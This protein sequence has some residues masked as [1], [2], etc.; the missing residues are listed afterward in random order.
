MRS[1]VILEFDLPQV[2]SRPKN[3]NYMNN[4]LFL[5][6][7][8]LFDRAKIIFV[9]VLQV[10]GGSPAETA[11]LQAGDTIIKINNTDIF[12]LRHKEAQDAI[13][14]AGNSF[15]ISISR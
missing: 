3:F 6:R 11:G 13:V 12:N 9:F 5:Y 4:V 14:K 15:E 7:P 8:K 1:T 10:N 2:Q